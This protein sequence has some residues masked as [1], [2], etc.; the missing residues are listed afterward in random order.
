MLKWME[1]NENTWELVI[2]YSERLNISML[3]IEKIDS[4]YY[5]SSNAM[6]IKKIPLGTD[7]LEEAKK[8]AVESLSDF[9]DQQ[10]EYYTEMEKVWQIEFYTEIKKALMKGTKEE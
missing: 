1:M 9:V 10:I 3:K 8:L 5:I 2:A 7:S 6:K 4:D